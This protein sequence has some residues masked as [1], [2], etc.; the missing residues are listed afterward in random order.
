MRRAVI[1]AAVIAGGLAVAAAT[2]LPP[3]KN[4]MPPEDLAAYLAD[5]GEHPA[6][7]GITHAGVLVALWLNPEIGSWS[8]VVTGASGVSCQILAGYHWTALRAPNPENGDDI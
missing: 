1:L 6:E 7:G 3:G 2:P 4:C 5:Y 8:L